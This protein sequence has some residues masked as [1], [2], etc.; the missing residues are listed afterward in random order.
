MLIV[1]AWILMITGDVINL[2]DFS[3]SYFPKRLR[4]V[5]ELDNAIGIIFLISTSST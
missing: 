1:F 2:L 3:M 5:Y 4:A